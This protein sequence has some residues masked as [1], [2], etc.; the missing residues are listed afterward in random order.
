MMKKLHI[1]G[2][3][4]LRELTNDE[5][6]HYIYGMAIILHPLQLFI[7]GAAN[8]KRRLSFCTCQ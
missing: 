4:K 7:S 6:C 1:I 3:H 8:F 5:H 2:L